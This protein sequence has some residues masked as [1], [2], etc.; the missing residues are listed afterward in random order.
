MA[1]SSPSPFR[2]RFRR[3]PLIGVHLYFY[4]VQS[5]NTTKDPW[6]NILELL[7][8][9]HTCVASC[10]Q[11]CN[12]ESTEACSLR[13]FLSLQTCLRCWGE[14]WRIFILENCSQI[15]LFWGRLMTCLCYELF[16]PLPS[17]ERAETSAT[18]TLCVLT[19]DRRTRI[20]SEYDHEAN[21]TS[22]DAFHFPLDSP[23]LSLC[24]IYSFTNCRYFEICNGLECDN[25]PPPP[26]PACSS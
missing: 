17:F 22:R 25:H 24:R 15:K 20:E 18:V 7:F 13:W 26:S 1:F 12:V 6:R 11:S 21:N 5:L 9:G 4:P 10:Q 8:N 3:R 14:K 23:L 16:W 2:S 19:N